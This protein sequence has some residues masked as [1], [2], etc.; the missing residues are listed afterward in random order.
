[1]HKFLWSQTAVKD[2]EKEETCPTRWK[3]QWLD[4]S[5]PSISNE[6]MDRGKYFEQLLL[7]HSANEKDI[8]TDLPRLDNGTKSTDQ[9]RIEAQAERGKRILSNPNDSEYLGFGIVSTQLRLTNEDESGVIDIEATDGKNDWIIDVKLTRDLTNVR[10]IYGWGNELSKMDLLQ[11]AHYKSLYFK[12]F[13]REPKL[14]VLIFDYSPKK[15]I[16]FSEIILSDLKAKEKVD[17][18]NMAKDV[19]KLYSERGWIKTP[20][21]G[22]CEKCNIGCSVR[23]YPTKIIKEIVNY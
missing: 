17:R 18:F 7:G 9:I 22:E 16:K 11:F 13:E 20:S 8:I 5:I 4:G 6:D 10:T 2:L 12:N 15:R 23:E 19:V 1:M 14:G 21:I 3:A